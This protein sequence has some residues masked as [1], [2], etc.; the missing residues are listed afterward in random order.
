MHECTSS[1]EARTV[2]LYKALYKLVR[3]IRIV[4]LYVPC[5]TSLDNELVRMYLYAR[6][7]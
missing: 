5:T 6:K 3:T 4:Q 2:L 7:G 1:H